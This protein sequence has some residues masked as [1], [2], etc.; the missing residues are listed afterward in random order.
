MGK[1]YLNL[2]SERTKK[3][4]IRATSISKMNVAL[5]EMV[6]EKDYPINKT[7]YQSPS[8]D[9]CKDCHNHGF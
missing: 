4:V 2:S 1:I 7:N 9:K 3:V 8:D 6:N 5:E